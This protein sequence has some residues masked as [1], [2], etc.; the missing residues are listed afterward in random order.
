M[1]FSY[2][3][4]IRCLVLE[5]ILIYQNSWSNA[6]NL[7]TLLV[8][9]LWHSLFVLFF[10][11]ILLF[12][13]Y[14]EFLVSAFVFLTLRRA[15]CCSLIIYLFSVITCFYFITV[16]SLCELCVNSTLSII[17]IVYWLILLFVVW[18]DLFILFSDFHSR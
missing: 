4:L 7:L 2:H 14:V 18:L 12:Y 5:L 16:R 8:N 6:V 3:S 15:F 10:Q 11:K 9:V 1:I 17:S 13:N